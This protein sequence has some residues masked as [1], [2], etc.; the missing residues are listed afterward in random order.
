MRRLFVAVGGVI[1]V[2]VLGTASF[3]AAGSEAD[4][5]EAAA[6]GLDL[7]EVTHDNTA[8]DITY[9]A[10]TFDADPYAVTPA[11]ETIQWA[12]DFND[13]ATADVCIEAD[14]SDE[15]ALTGRA[16]DGDCTSATTLGT[17]TDV[18]VTYDDPAHT[19]T[20][21]WPRSL[22]ST[23]TEANGATDY[24]YQVAATSGTGG[25]AVVDNVPDAPAETIT[26]DLTLAQASPTPSPSASAT[27]TPDDSPTATVDPVD[28][29]TT[30]TS[31]GTDS[32]ALP[33][34]GDMVDASASAWP[35]AVGLLAVLGG[36]SLGAVLAY[37]LVVGRQSQ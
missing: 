26:H 18:E 31:A 27:A 23:I 6:A 8:D 2:V 7:A 12:L 32:G 36:L 37:K 24:E 13:D 9:T 15:T 33:G 25:A 28:T 35:T 17:A 14:V 34:T 5:D 1:C 19:Y 30:T 16:L 4:P 11:P 10:E 22:L 21:T 29:T 20:V 3:A